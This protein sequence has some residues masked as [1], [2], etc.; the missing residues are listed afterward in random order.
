MLYRSNS[1]ITL[2]NG[3][4]TADAMGDVWRG[5][6]VVEM[7]SRVGADM[8]VSAD[9]SRRW[10]RSV[11]VVVSLSIIFRIRCWSS[12]D[13][14]AATTTTTTTTTC[15]GVYGCAYNIFQPP[16][17]FLRIL[18]YFVS[19]HLTRSSPSAPACLPPIAA[20]TP[21]QIIY[22]LCNQPQCIR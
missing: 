2:E 12:T 10:E 1:W 6:E 22:M 3:K 13:E 21:R 15:D 8:L 9:V 18:L 5:L 17:R 20:S 7:A 11:L 4:T 19:P 16:V 14:L